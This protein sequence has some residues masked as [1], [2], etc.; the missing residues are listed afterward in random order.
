MKVFALLMLLGCKDERTVTIT[1]KPGEA[2]E[3]HT[4]NYSGSVGEVTVLIGPM[5]VV[6]VIIPK[7]L[8]VPY[9]AECPLAEKLEKP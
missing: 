8:L 3:V 4:L 5:R 1:Q 9:K 2:V 7:L 6:P